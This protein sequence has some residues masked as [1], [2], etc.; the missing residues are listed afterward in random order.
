MAFTEAE[1]ILACSPDWIASIRGDLQM[2]SRWSD[3]TASIGEMAEAAVEFD[4]DYI[5]ITDH[6]KGLKIAGGIDETRLSEQAVE[7]DTVNRILENAGRKL[8]VL[9]S[10]ELNLSPAGNGDLDAEALSRLDIVIGCFHSSLRRKE[11][12]TDRYLAALR[13]PS[14]QILGHPRGRI[15]NYRAGLSAKWP[16]VF[17]LAAELDKAVEIDAYPDR[18]DLSP[19]LLADAKKAGCRISFGTDSHGPTQLRFMA[20]AAA[21]ALRAGIARDRIVNFFPREELLAWVR[22]VR[23]RAKT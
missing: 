20:F 18:Q 17:A 5:A 13:N 11:D 8:R 4:Y 10:I 14:I 9:R 15:Y 23:E 21:S 22:S 16:R 3:G 12:Q 19:D 1:S 6:A 2:H 7:I